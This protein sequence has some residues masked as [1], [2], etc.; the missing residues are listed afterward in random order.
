MET[1]I[2]ALLP[3][4]GP[5]AAEQPIDYYSIAMIGASSKVIDG[6]VYHWTMIQPA[7]PW[8]CTNCLPT[9]TNCLK[10]TVRRRS[11]PLCSL[12]VS[13][14]GIKKQN[15]NEA[16]MKRDTLLVTRH[17]HTAQVNLYDDVCV[18]RIK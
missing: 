3:P 7:T 11:S 6:D 15:T 5:I 17:T 1:R 2:F 12:S 8:Y 9:P 10:T 14:G 18:S 13:P 16:Q 4:A